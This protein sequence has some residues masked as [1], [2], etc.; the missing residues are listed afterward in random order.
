[1]QKK[2]KFLVFDVFTGEFVDE[3][4]PETDFE[5]YMQIVEAEKEIALKMIKQRLD[6]IDL[7]EYDES[8]D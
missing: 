2:N 5:S 4:P 7:K 6:K 8:T 3:L 1:M